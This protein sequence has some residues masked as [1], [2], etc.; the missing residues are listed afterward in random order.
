MWNLKSSSDLTA[1]DLK[2]VN[3][4]TILIKMSKDR[5]QREAWFRVKMKLLQALTLISTDSI[6]WMFLYNK[7]SALPLNSWDQKKSLDVWEKYLMTNNTRSLFTSVLLNQS[8]LKLELN[9]YCW[10]IQ[11]SICLFGYILLN[12]H[13][14]IPI[15]LL[16]SFQR[17]QDL[18][19]WCVMFP[20]NEILIL[21]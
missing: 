10:V 14:M 17:L 9:F 2:N 4:K 5:R 13:W 21:K 18:N 7:K 11:P 8:F 3:L 15:L 20:S 19:H 16:T 1:Y 12:Y 6:I